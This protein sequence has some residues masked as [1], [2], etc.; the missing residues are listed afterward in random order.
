MELDVVNLN[1]P[2]LLSRVSIL[3][4]QLVIDAKFALGHPR[5]LGL[6]HD[7][8]EDVSLEHRASDGHKN[9]DVFDYVDED[10]VSLVP[11]AFCSP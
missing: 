11:Y 5:Q 3:D 4:E 1:A 6:D 2:I 7:L 10:L 8:A 9:I